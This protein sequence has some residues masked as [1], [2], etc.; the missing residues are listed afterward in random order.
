MAK[1]PK[2]LAFAG[3]L[4]EHSFNKRVLRVAIAGARAAGADVTE[5]DLRDYPMPLYNADEHAKNGFDA[6]AARFQQTLSEHDGLLIATP[7]Y[8]GSVPG[9]LKNAIDWASRKSDKFGMVEVFKGKTAAM[10][11]ASPGAFGGLRC[12]AH[13]RGVLSIML[14]NV[15]PME[16]AVTFVADKFQADAE[17][18]TDEKTKKILED[19]GAQL[20]EMLKK[21]GVEASAAGE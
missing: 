5:L 7:E 8:N 1:K 14:V 16:I 12:L 4:R 21:T 2:I 17:E 15:L 20:A 11:T 9:G 10:I 13:L 19:L 3:S 18:M 6:N